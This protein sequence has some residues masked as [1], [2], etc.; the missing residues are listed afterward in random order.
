MYASRSS[1]TPGL[2]ASA[3]GSVG[4]H[5]GPAPPDGTEANWIPTRAAEQFEII[6]RVYGVQKPLL[7]K[8]WK[9]PDIEPV[10]EPSAQVRA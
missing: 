4:L 8:T 3:D 2:V 1:L 6:F 10:S 9:L 5:F 7:D